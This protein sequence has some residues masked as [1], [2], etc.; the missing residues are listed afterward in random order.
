MALL[1]VFDTRGAYNV[2]LEKAQADSGAETLTVGRSSQA[3]IIIGNDDGISRRHAL[4]SRISGQWAIEDLG[5]RNGTWLNGNALVGRRILRN[6][7]EIRLG[8]TIL[9]FRDYSDDDSSTLKGGQAPPI[10]GR[11]REVL[12]ELCRPYFFSNS[13]TKKAASKADIAAAL[14][15]GEPAVQAQLLNLYDRFGI[16][17]RRGERRDLLADIVMH[18]GVI[19][20]RDYLND[21]DDPTSG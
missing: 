9:G 3:Q 7:D 17:G 19:T 16:E 1:D 5:A 20:R 13:P 8:S 18:K 4:L 15:V 10:T 11:Q 2:D 12:V 21:G 6:G 14:F